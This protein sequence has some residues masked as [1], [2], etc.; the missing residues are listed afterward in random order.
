M[1][2]SRKIAAALDDPARPDPRALPCEV[3]AEEGGCRVSLT[4]TANGPVGL[5]FDD[6]TFAGPAGD[7]PDGALRS[8]AE[9]VAA[10]VTYLMEPLVILEH[11]P[12]AGEVELRSRTPT[13]R[14]E[15]RSHYEARLRR[16]G[17]LRLSRVVTDAATRRRRPAP[18]Q[19]TREAL[20]RLAD[21]LADCAP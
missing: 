9:R 21:D 20:E 1:S 4:M 7:L 15:S 18:C 12:L 5:A 17:T 16:D 6:L 19:M 8:W 2:L 13:E 10:R 11:D 3:A 14:G